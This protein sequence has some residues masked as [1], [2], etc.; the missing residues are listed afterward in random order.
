MVLDTLALQ[1]PGILE[2]FGIL[3]AASG[4]ALHMGKVQVVPFLLDNLED[5]RSLVV[6]L[7]PAFSHAKFVQAAKYLGIYIGVGRP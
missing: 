2:K 4:L 6:L 1:L 5:F 3:K 7:S